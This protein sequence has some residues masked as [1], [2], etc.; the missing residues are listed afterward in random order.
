MV[1][2]TNRIQTTLVLVL[3]LATSAGCQSTKYWWN[4]GKKVGPN[5]L[6]P[7]ATVAQEYRNSGQNNEVFID[8]NPASDS[9]WWKVFDDP[10]LDSLIQ[11]LTE[12]NLSLKT[13]CFRI[14][15]ARHLRN[16]A[17]ANL[18]P[19]FQAATGQA[20]HTQISQNSATAFPGGPLTVNDLA[21]GFD[22][23]WEVDLWGRI[24]RSIAASDASLQASIHDYNFAL[25][26][27]IGDTASLYIQIRS[28]DERIDL[29]NKNVEL[30]KGSLEI[31]E[32]RF[33]EGRTD[34]LDVVQAKSNLASTQALIP[35]FE[36]AR[37]Q[38]LNAL[39][40]LLGMAPGDVPY[41]SSTTGRIPDVPADVIVGIP[42]DLLR[43]RPDILAA[44]RTMAAQFENIGIAEADL[45]PTFAINGT[46]GWQAARVSDLFESASFN[47]TVAPGFSWKILNYGRLNQAISVEEARFKQAQTQFE[48][49]VL[50][51]QAEVEDGIIE[52]IKKKEQYVFDEVT[53][54]ANEESVELAVASF[55]EGKTDFGRVF[56]VQTNLV[57]AQDKL[58]ETRTSIALALIKTYKALG[59]G[60]ES[61]SNDTTLQTTF[62]EDSS[63]S[64]ER[65]GDNCQCLLLGQ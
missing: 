65:C 60:W 20:S 14:K 5:Y 2:L 59:G 22:A 26:T 18:F 11:Q 62:N 41:L 28:L 6:Q 40:V 63:D 44:E 4:N 10:D 21:V 13:A 9:Q 42:A 45:Y 35:Q 64:C 39:C 23:S 29:A 25:V 53:A 32:N 48:L 24:R 30:Q 56:V 61:G 3:L 7:A 15:E 54:E 16:I 46:L 55:K 36:L 58:V 38:S 51:A 49:S 47:G 1:Q 52:F 57:V 17:S 31:A 37:R 33:E 12:Q 34:K 19:Q 8:M 50:A 43:R 27:L